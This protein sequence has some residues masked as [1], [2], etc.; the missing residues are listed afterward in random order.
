MVLQTFH[1]APLQSFL[2]FSDIDARIAGNIRA[3]G[4]ILPDELVSVLNSSF[5]PELV[6]MAEV[7][8]DAELL[9]EL[10]VA[11]EQ[12]IV[13]PGDRFHLGIPLLHS[14]NG[15]FE[16]PYRYGI[17]LLKQG[18]AKLPVCVDKEQSLAVLSRLD[19]VPFHIADPLSV[20]DS[21]GSLVNASLVR[22][23]SRTLLSPWF[24]FTEFV[25][26]RLDSPS[27]GTLDIGAYGNSRHIGEVFVILQNA[28]CNMLGRLVVQEIFV[29][30][31]LKLR[32]LYDGIRA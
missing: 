17:Y 22:E 20:V 23:P 5:F 31:L 32:M 7:D 27:V 15:V 10:L 9:L 18:V 8:L 13:V 2:K 26:V 25:S 6:G 1:D 3:L 28:L 14:R 4:N 30:R 16:S 24:A 21:L 19:E 29:D 11:D 12:N